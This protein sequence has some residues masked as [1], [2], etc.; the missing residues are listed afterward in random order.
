MNKAISNG[1]ELTYRAKPEDPVDHLASYFFAQSADEVLNP[2]FDEQVNPLQHIAQYLM[3]NNPL[4]EASSDEL[5]PLPHESQKRI[6][7]PPV[8]L[9]ANAE[10]P[11]ISLKN[12]KPRDYS[13]P[14]QLKGLISDNCEKE[15]IGVIERSVPNV[16][17]G[18]S[19]KY[20]TITAIRHIERKTVLFRAIGA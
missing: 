17:V 2:E 5:P 20:V 14:A 12:D 6:F 18:G 7:V 8:P 10:A 15:V 3:R 11:P 13:V 16:G 4:H 1:L 19:S 9:L